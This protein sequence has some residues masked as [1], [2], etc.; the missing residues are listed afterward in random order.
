MMQ[1]F[2]VLCAF[3]ALLLVPGVALAQAL[4]APSVYVPPAPDAGVR[5]AAL[6]PLEQEVVAGWLA[7]GYPAFVYGDFAG[8]NA[9]LAKA[10]VEKGAVLEAAVNQVIGLEG[11]AFFGDPQFDGEAYVFLGAVESLDATAMRLLA[12][13]SALGEGDELWVIAPDIARP[14]GP[15]TAA[16]HVEGGRWLPT[17]FGES[18]VLA[19]RSA[20]PVFPAMTVL[21]YAHFY[22]DFEEDAAKAEFACPV[23]VACVSEGSFQDASSGIGRLIIPINGGQGLCSGSL[24]N[25]P[26]TIPLEPFF[27]TA[28]HC[29]QNRPNAANVEVKWDFRALNCDG[30]GVPSLNSVPSSGGRAYLARSGTFDGEFIELVS[31]PTGDFGRTY[32]GWDTAARS[33]GERVAGIHHP[34][35]EPMK[36]AFGRITATGVST[37]LGE[38]QNRVIWDDGITKGG[39]SGSP[40]LLR[41]NGFLVVGMLS[42][43]NVHDC[44]TPANNF[45]NYASFRDFFPVIQCFLTDNQNCEEPDTGLCPVEKAFEEYPGVIAALREFRDGVLMRSAPGRVFVEAYY[46]AAPHISAWM[47]DHPERLALAR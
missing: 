38:Q 16:D 20:V 47:D 6:Y 33:V 31:V 18:V 11:A 41:D 45:D 40:L 23:Q 28:N 10:A 21:A 30:S 26:S 7:G 3:S 17:V 25:N 29:F 42:S 8:Q 12:N 19:V 46:A 2:A 32:L 36:G 1:R 34:A 5:K 22:H 35:G 13:L 24:I 9:A 27:L 4:R 37:F 44:A 43:G 14:F 15:Y 39:S